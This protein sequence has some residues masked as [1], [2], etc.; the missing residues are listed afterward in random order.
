MPFAPLRENSYT[1]ETNI[2]SLIFNCMINSKNGSPRQLSGNA[3][4]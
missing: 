4:S 1:K 3:F 2:Q